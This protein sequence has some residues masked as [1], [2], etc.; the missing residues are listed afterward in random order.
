MK[1]KKKN[2]DRS[3]WFWA[4]IMRD[5][6]CKYIVISHTAVIRSVPATVH[7]SR[8]G[9]IIYTYLILYTYTDMYV[10]AVYPV[11]AVP[12]SFGPHASRQRTR[13]DRTHVRSSRYWSGWIRVGSRVFAGGTHNVRELTGLFLARKPGES[14]RT[15]EFWNPV[16]RRWNTNM[17]LKYSAAGWNSEPHLRSVFVIKLSGSNRFNHKH[18]WTQADPGEFSEPR[19]YHPLVGQENQRRETGDQKGVQA[20]LQRG[21]STYETR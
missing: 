17:V 18:V 8:V 10:G 9:N 7:A 19:N 15:H 14:Y 20:S 12:H 2:I 4:R 1:F 21:K 3:F 16:P 5:G 6:R 13:R 11:D